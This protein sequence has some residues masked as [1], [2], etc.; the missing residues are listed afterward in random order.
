MSLIEQVQA[1]LCQKGISSDLKENGTELT[2]FILT[3]ILG[4]RLAIAERDGVLQC[5]VLIPLY[6][7][8]YRRTE[9]ALAV[10]RAN[11]GLIGG[12]FRID[13]AD[14]ELRYECFLPVLDGEPTQR[15]LSWLIHRSWVVSC[16]YAQALA[17]VA[18]S[19]VTPEDAINRAE[20]S[21]REEARE[22]PVV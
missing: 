2:T 20:A 9:V 14:G 10:T 16:R 18:L 7:P 8:E 1:L 17:E 4:S 12:S 11:W 21:W 5:T 22:L 6:V 3:G 19:S 15:Q 13:L